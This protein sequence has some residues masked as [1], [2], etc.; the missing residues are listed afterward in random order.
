VAHFEKYGAVWDCFLYDNDRK[1]FTQSKNKRFY[2]FWAR[3][4]RIRKFYKN[5]DFDLIKKERWKSDHKSDKQL[6]S[7]LES[8]QRLESLQSLQSLQSL[9]SLERL[10]R[11]QSLQ[12]LERLES[13]QRL[14]RLEILE[15]LQRLEILESLQRLERLQNLQSLEILERLQSL[16]SLESLESL[17]RLQSLQSLE[18]LEVYNLDYRK[19]QLPKKDDCII[20]LDPPYKWTKKYETDFNYEEFYEF[21][22]DLKEKW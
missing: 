3:W 15:S 20:Y 1:E 14:E 10:E 4:K 19:V 22:R 7:D 11:L 17:E 12:S 13:L 5:F 18:R 21:V 16:Q 8:L 9:E 2:K 6:L